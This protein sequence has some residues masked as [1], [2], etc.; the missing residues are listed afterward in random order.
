MSVRNERLP[1]DY[2]TAQG[3]EVPVE[4]PALVP[5]S[6][7]RPQVPELRSGFRQTVNASG[8]KI[9]LGRNKDT[10]IEGVAAR[11][12]WIPFWP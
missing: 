8:A 2:A 7:L 10:A 12:R 4:R 9:W 5:K 6:L 3:P 11:L 1:L